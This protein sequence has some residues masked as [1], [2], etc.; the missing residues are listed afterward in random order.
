MKSQYDYTAPDEVV[1][2]PLKNFKPGEYEIVAH[3][4]SR[5]A[6][7]SESIQW[8]VS[9]F[10]KRNM[11][12]FA[13]ILPI[14]LIMSVVT[15]D[16]LVGIP[17]ISFLDGRYG[18]CFL[19]VLAD[20]LLCLLFQIMIWLYIVRSEIMVKIP[21]KDYLTH[22]LR[23][24]KEKASSVAVLFSA[25][26]VIYA[27]IVF[28]TCLLIYLLIPHNEIDIFMNSREYYLQQYLD[29]SLMDYRDQ[30]VAREITRWVRELDAVKI[31]PLFK[32]SLIG[33]FTAIIGGFIYYMLTI[34]ALPLVLF[35]RVGVMGALVESFKGF[36]KNVLS[37]TVA[38]LFVLIIDAGVYACFSA[39]PFSDIMISTLTTSFNIFIFYLSAKTIFWNGNL[40]SFS[41]QQK[42]NHETVSGNQDSH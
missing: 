13:K 35:S 14:A 25:H 18:S 7:V 10:S 28:S 24:F 37:L 8:F 21:V 30:N 32:I 27:L 38:G 36:S 15:S 42:V 23:V 17:L 33:S 3:F 12:T 1:P 39:V 34:Y 26:I 40:E 4:P 20:L 19:S 11:L 41:S 22:V 5:I 16:L 6:R 2:E 31:A 29:L 9:F